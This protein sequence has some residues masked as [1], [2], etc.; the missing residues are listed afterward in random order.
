M[1]TSQFFVYHRPIAWV[2]LLACLLWG[3]FG[4]LRMPQRLDPIIPIGNAVVVTSYPGASA[5]EVEQ[6]V[7]RKVELALGEVAG[8]KRTYSTSRPGFSAVFVELHDS[9][10]DTD[11]HWLELQRRLSAIPDLPE[12]NGVRVHPLLN[13]DFGDTV[14][15][16][17]TLSAPPVSDFELNLRANSIIETLQQTRAALPEATRARRWAGV[18]V[19][20]DTVARSYVL[21]IGRNLLQQMASAGMLVGP[22][23]I[24][25]APG[26]G[27]I[28]FELAPGFTVADLEHLTTRLHA[29]E[30]NG[31]VHPDIW[32]GLWVQDLTTLPQAL[33]RVASDRY[34]YRQL[35]DFA[36]HTRDRLRQS[37]T[38]AK[39]DLI[40]VQEEQVT[41]YYSGQRF[42]QYGLAPH[43]VLT[44][45]QARN[46]NLPG[47]RVELP[48]QNIIVKP[49]GR[50]T[51]AT[52]IGDV[53][54]GTV[55]EFGY[56]LYLRDLVE[57]VRGYQDPPD[58]MNF[59]TVKADTQKP[60]T[61]L[62]PGE[63]QPGTFSLHLN[64]PPPAEYQLQNGR[65]ITLAIQQVKGS[66]I[67][68]FDKDLTQALTELQATLPAD[69]RI[70][71]TSDEPTHVVERLSEFNSCLIEAILIVI[72]CCVLIMEWRSAALVAISIPL[73]IAMTLGMCQLIGIDV[74]QV[75]I[76]ALIIALG[77]LVDDPV[78]AADAINRSLATGKTPDVAAWYGP[79]KLARAIMYATLTN[80]VAF[81][82]LLLIEG[83]TGDFVYSLPVMVATSLVASRIVSMTFVPLLGYYLL[84]GQSSLNSQT[85]K[86]LAARGYYALC[87][88]CVNHKA[89]VLSGALVALLVGAGLT[90]QIG[91]AF[92][93]KDLQQV[94]VVNVYL[95]E[96]A[97]I[98][99]SQKVAQQVIARMDTLEGK[100]LH[101]FTTFVGAGGPRFWLS[102]AP[103]QRADNYAQIL[104]HTN[105]RW[106][107][108][109]VVGR[110]K[111]SLPSGIAEARVT[112]Q[113]LE[114]GPPI[115]MPVQ[116]RIM[117]PEVGTLR[118]LAS[119]A[120]EL[121]RQIPGAD[122]IHDDWEPENFQIPLA[123]NADRA[124]LVG[125]SNQ[126]VAA[127]VG[128]GLAGATVTYMQDGEYSI[129][130]VLRLRPSERS[131]L[132][133][134]F[135][136]NAMSANGKARVPMKQIIDIKEP[137][138][139]AP[140]IARRDNERCL[141][142]LCDALPGS[143]PSAIV[144]NLQKQLDSITLPPGY[145]FQFGGEVEE[146]SKGF[147]S[148]AFALV[149]SLV[150][151]YL[152]LVLQF[153]SVTKPLV[154]Y[155]AVPFGMVGGLMGLL[156]FNSPFGFMAFLGVA[157]L[158][159]VIVSHIIVLFDYIEEEHQ[160]GTPVRQAVIEAGLA[161]LR[162][163]VVTV[164]ATIGG[165]IPLALRG[166][167]LWEPLCYV[168]IIG[169]AVASFV[170]ML[171][172]PVLYV[173]FV[174]NLKLIRW[175]KPKGPTAPPHIGA[176][177]PPTA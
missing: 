73:T 116:L 75:S 141:T 27:C 113:Q 46:T 135:S 5:L 31:R 34:T 9:V 146:Q 60:L 57:V 29:Q 93:P 64:T 139:V 16:L 68:T 132:N 15:V 176:E 30:G 78:V 33:R 95:P 101:S 81:L 160:H 43:D 138:F 69:L 149:V 87:H 136:L 167:P 112:V 3:V 110:L 55:S 124:N 17:L 106:Q 19:Y 125:I 2:A 23:H 134:L 144:T 56:P 18:L 35:R 89:V 164:L 162:P 94:F 82:P 126:D 4:Y 53:V 128:T 42:T 163:V 44:R 148:V 14:A 7:S 65:A 104:V 77:L 96:G 83:K 59:R 48:E 72:A 105:D 151:I 97:P 102:I 114:T 120:K 25:E 121:L 92:F 37:P 91:S 63:I 150:A 122:N 26:A 40:G 108:A 8:V 137:E 157:S 129:P 166:G 1:T 62:L 71:R 45:L 20:P 145:R 161:R 67:H 39:V 168:L 173:W 52:E 107:T 147:A 165:L 142:V 115:G 50:F 13:K 153:N 88:W 86:N 80:C 22:A 58:V 123:V 152:A 100:H 47:G 169:L 99:Q 32:P 118:L 79:D 131:Q 98:Q 130:V 119:Q 49:S 41:L 66:N 117:G 172:V 51:S 10:R 103:E 140:K 155:A 174:E 158:A 133:D 70:E 109:A 159:G 90:T 177:F 61:A 171:L 54:T 28:D 6:E 156:M 111:Q 175:D 84:R 74:Q 85:H 76:A 127:I 154:V 143:L 21:R 24:V 36:Q 12:V 170:T 38:V 11:L